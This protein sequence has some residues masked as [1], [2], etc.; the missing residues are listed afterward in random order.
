MRA[1][2][3]RKAPN[4]KRSPSGPFV[5]TATWW[6]LTTQSR[7]RTP[8]AGAGAATVVGGAGQGPG[9]LGASRDSRRLAVCFS[10]PRAAQH[11]LRT[12]FCQLGCGHFTGQAPGPSQ[13][14]GRGAG[15]SRQ[16]AAFSSEG[17]LLLC[18][19][20]ASQPHTAFGAR[21]L[22][23]P[24]AGTLR[25]GFSCGGVGDVRLVSQA[26]L[27][28]VSGGLFAGRAE[29]QL[30]SPASCQRSSRRSTAVA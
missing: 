23:G 1:S 25:P 24:G 2:P 7:P 19:N 8:D 17:F 11:L 12:S 20:S 16:D 9:A 22:M 10:E 27:G 30:W 21:Q 15:H 3:L 6:I 18:E 4:K 5:S 14:E 28:V 13:S 26:Q 29:R